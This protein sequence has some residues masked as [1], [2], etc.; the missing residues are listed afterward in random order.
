MNITDIAFP[1]LNIYLQNVPRSISVFGF[2]IAFY[3][4]IVALGFFL[5]ISLASA[6]ANRIGLKKD[7]WWDAAVWLILFTIIGARIY[8]VIFSWDMYKND[9]LGIFNLRNGGLAIYG[10]VIA[11]FLTI[12]IY[13]RIAKINYAAMADAG[14]LG[15]LLGQIMGRWGNFFNREVFGRYTDNIFAMRLPIDAVRASDITPDLAAHIQEGTNYIQVHPT[16]FYESALNLLLL[17]LLL[18]YRKHK[19]FDGELALCYFLGYGVIRFVMEGVRTDRLMLFNTNIAVSQ[20]LSAVM[21]VFALIMLIIMH[22][23]AH[24]GK[25]TLTVNTAGGVN[26]G[27]ADK[28]GRNLLE[29]PDISGT[30]VKAAGEKKNDDLKIIEI[31]E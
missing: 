15:L 3:G 29:E 1:N 23:R 27:S 11:G 4:I 24:M 26:G 22:I 17:I 25:A 18:L 28:T 19:K 16:F 2:E 5:G 9:L 8:Y 20:A 10:G 12:F 13:T 14:V 21:V 30:D 7:C 6:E 31:T